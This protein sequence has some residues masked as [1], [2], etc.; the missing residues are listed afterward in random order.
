MSKTILEAIGEHEREFN[1]EHRGDSCDFAGCR[2]W[3]LCSNC[4]GLLDDHNPKCKDWE[5]FWILSVGPWD[6][7]QS[8]SLKYAPGGVEK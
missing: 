6:A 4:K 3:D 8:Y 2:L 1:E 7:M 5:Y